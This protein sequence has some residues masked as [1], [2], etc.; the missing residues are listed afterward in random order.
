MSGLCDVSSQT[1]RYCK[2]CKKDTL[3]KK[4][5]TGIGCLG[6]VLVFILASSVIPL[7]CAGI[8]LILLPIAIIMMFMPEEA[9]CQTCGAKNMEKSNKNNQPKPTI[10]PP[11]KPSSKQQNI[12]TYTRCPD[13]KKSITILNRDNYYWHCESCG[14]NIPIKYD[15]PVCNQELKIINKGQEYYICCEPCGIKE[16]YYTSKT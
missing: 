5:N 13:C 10:K 4:P 1:S 12:E 2:K 6:F 11:A 3:H 16:L 8:I 7:L 15:C 9:T 14:K